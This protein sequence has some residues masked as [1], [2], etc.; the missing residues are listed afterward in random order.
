MVMAK[1]GG[2][3]GKRRS[4]AKWVALVLLGGV[5]FLAVKAG[6]AAFAWA[7]IKS[8]T[9]PRDDALLAWIPADTTVVAVVDPHQMSSKVLGAP[10]GLVRASIERLCSDIQKAT[11]V[12]L[13]FDVDKVAL[14]PSLIVMRGRFDGDRITQKLAEYG[15]VRSDYQGRHTVV[16]AGEDALFVSDDEVI[17]YG[18]EPA[19]KAS[20]DAHGGISL[21]NNDQ[22]VARLAQIGWNH[23]V[24]G[25]VRLGADR[26]SL[27]AMIAGTSGPHAVTFGA[28][29]AKGIQVEASV[30]AGSANAS[31]DLGR[32]LEEKRMNAADALRNWGPDLAAQIAQVARTAAVRVDA[33]SASVR[34]SA[35]LSP[36]SI[37]ALYKAASASPMVAET[38]KGYR[39]AQLLAPNP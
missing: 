17:V 39:L 38:F 36:D 11:G 9:V 29:A 25:T 32:L 14:T 12:D 10:R 6:W 30:E 23:A 28:R 8:A 1:P 16:R 22:V 34:L 20:A 21:A 31:E 3:G 15:Y 2:V 24:I 13:A 18:D 4:R 27:R 7:R 26:P 35:T 19:I 37:D 33:P 5:A